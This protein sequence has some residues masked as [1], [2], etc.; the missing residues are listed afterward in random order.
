MYTSAMKK[1]TIELEFDIKETRVT[2]ISSRIEIVGR[3]DIFWIIEEENN[4]YRLTFLGE[5]VTKHKR[6]ESVKSTIRSNI[7]EKLD[8]ILKK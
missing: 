3:P 2:D 1:I 8:T 7:V 5:K 6:R 4:G